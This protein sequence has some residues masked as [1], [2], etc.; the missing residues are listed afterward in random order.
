MHGRLGTQAIKAIRLA[1]TTVAL[2]WALGP[3]AGEVAAGHAWLAP[4][5]AV[6]TNVHYRLP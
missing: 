3:D 5:R 4:S 1:P 2:A 6:Y